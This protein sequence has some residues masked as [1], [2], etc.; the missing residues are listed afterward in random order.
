MNLYLIRHS[1]AEKSSLSK[2]DLN[3]ELTSEGINL[4]IRGGKF[5]RKVAP[6]LGLILSSPYRR[7]FQTAEIITESF[8]NKVNL[9]K[10]NNL[11][12]GCSTSTLI[13]VVSLY[14]EQNIAIIGHQPDIS[15]HISNLTSNDNINLIF[16]PA[17]ISKISFESKIG[18]NKGVLEIL[19][20]SEVIY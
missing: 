13:D 16:K 6:D 9:I 3:R 19:I 8:D 12:A 11:A 5:L 1:I 14:Q 15:N 18:F 17:T 4:M 2:S 10:D 7:A 20:P